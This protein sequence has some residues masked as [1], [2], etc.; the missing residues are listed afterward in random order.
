MSECVC[1]GFNL[2]RRHAPRRVSAVGRVD[3]SIVQQ[4]EFPH[5]GLPN[6]QQK[7]AGAG[8]SAR[9]ANIP[10][11]GP[12]GPIGLTAPTPT[13]G[14]E[15]E[16]QVSKLEAMKKTAQE[17]GDQGLLTNIEDKL[18]HAL[19]TPLSTPMPKKHHWNKTP[20]RAIH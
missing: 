8:G 11:P 1:T 2:A 19:Q 9:H 12:A 16:Q 3:L 14:N 13:T 10:P 17:L 15:L 18:R 7:L 6:E 20:V 5:E 4:E